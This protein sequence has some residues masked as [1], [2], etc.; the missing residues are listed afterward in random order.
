MV[1]V[2]EKPSCDDLL[3]EARQGDE[4]A[5]S[6]LWLLARTS[7]L[8]FAK[9]WG[10][11]S[12][13]DIVEEAGVSVLAALRA[14][15]GPQSNF[16][17]Y[18]LSVV[19]NLVHSKKVY[20]HDEPLAD[21]DENFVVAGDDVEASALEDIERVRIQAVFAAMKPR[22]VAL[23]KATA[24][25]GLSLGEAA[26]LLGMDVRTAAMAVT[27]ARRDFQ[28]RWVE[29]YVTISDDQPHE[30]RQTLEKIG[31]YLTCPP[32]N[33]VAKRVKD[34]LQHCRAC[35]E[36]VREIDYVAHMWGR[37][38]GGFLPPTLGNGLPAIAK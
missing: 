8:R 12:P 37:A 30:C 29:S 2:P 28:R 24:M 35:S 9:A 3:A 5:Y 14:G 15:K 25:D 13:E 36:T 32:G 27:R 1:G 16:T 11:D 4:D 6:Q 20:S 18:V 21:D 26:E 38:L 33:P 19:R 17:A 31:V 34:H 22:A 23:L 10:A 7:A